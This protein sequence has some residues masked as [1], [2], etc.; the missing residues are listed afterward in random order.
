VIRAFILPRGFFQY[1]RS[2]ETQ[3]FYTFLGNERDEVHWAHGQWNMRRG[4]VNEFT[5]GNRE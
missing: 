3:S 2:G 1:R 4:G 5:A